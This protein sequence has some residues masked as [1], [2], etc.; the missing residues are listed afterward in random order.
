MKKVF[1]WL[2]LSAGLA[3]S[4][5]IV[6]VPV[7]TVTDN[8][9]V[10]TAVP[11]EELKLIY[12]KYY[13]DKVRY[14][15]MTDGEAL[16]ILKYAKSIDGEY[17]GASGSTSLQKYAFN[18]LSR[19]EE[20]LKDLFIN[21]ATNEGK[22]YAL[23]RLAGIS[24][25]LYEKYYNQIDLDSFVRIRSGCSGDTVRIKDFLINP[26]DLKKSKTWK[27]GESGIRGVSIWK[28]GL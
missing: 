18:K 4:D 3:F 14:E 13:E 16:L 24:E 22:V 10:K 2:F 7:L 19:S 9:E 8:I 1:L 17:T 15:E 25:V 5:G 28:I 23:T 6:S 27:E 11:P 26:D 12:K 20:L 21:S